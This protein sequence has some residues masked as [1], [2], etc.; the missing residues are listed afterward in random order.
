MPKPAKR[1]R[2]DDAGASGHMLAS[3]VLSSVTCPISQALVVD[4]VMAED[5]AIYERDQITKWLS[6]NNRS[7][8][9]NAAMGARL[10]AAQNTRSLVESLLE[11]ESVDD[12]AAAA[13]HAASARKKITGALPGG[14][15]AAK[16]HLDRAAALDSSTECDVLRE[17]LALRDQHKGVLTKAAAA[18]VTREV[19]SILSGRT[20]SPMTAW[21]PDLKAG[22]II[23][24]I[25]DR[26]E[27]KRLFGRP[28]PGSQKAINIGPWPDYFRPEGREGRVVGV[29][30]KYRAYR[31]S[32]RGMNGREM[33]MIWPFD[34][35]I[36]IVENNSGNPP[37]SSD[38]SDDSSSDDSDIIGGQ[39]SFF[40]L[41]G[42]ADSDDSSSDSDDSSG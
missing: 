41:S 23:R 42:T 12:D 33:K 14:I 10:V 26:D 31:V 3:A 19:E 35:C 6:S 27:L 4:P 18:G 34:A 22:A 13:W 2:T 21:R 7:P 30:E 29:S 5:G 36:L 11:S 25:D 28:A 37:D 1:A 8:V 20:R 15:D 32:G 38:D 40:D 16:V 17:A 39:R 9:T 24:L